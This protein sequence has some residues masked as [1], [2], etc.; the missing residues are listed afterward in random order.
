MSKQAKKAR[1]AAVAKWFRGYLQ[2]RGLSRR[3][4]KEKFGWGEV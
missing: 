3:Q 2:R 1:F 4:F